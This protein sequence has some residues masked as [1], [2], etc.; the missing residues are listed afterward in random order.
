MKRLKHYLVCCLEFVFFLFIFIG[1]CHANPWLTAEERLEKVRSYYKENHNFDANTRST[2]IVEDFYE[3]DLRY[4]RA[5]YGKALNASVLLEALEKMDEEVRTFIG[6]KGRTLTFNEYNL[7]TREWLWAF[8][9]NIVLKEEDYNTIRS[10]ANN[11]D[12]LKQKVVRDVIELM[13]YRESINKEEETSVCIRLPF[14]HVTGMVDVPTMNR[15]CGFFFD[16]EQTT[17]VAFMGVATSPRV[18]YDSLVD[19]LASDGYDHDGLHATQQGFYDGDRPKILSRKNALINREIL[20]VADRHK[21][22][23]LDL[24]FFTASHEGATFRR[25]NKSIYCKCDLIKYSA[26]KKLKRDDS[27]DERELCR[28]KSLIGMAQSLGLPIADYPELSFRE[29]VLQQWTEYNQ[30][31]AQGCE[32]LMNLSLQ[33]FPEDKG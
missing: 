8:S 1:I 12:S 16:E 4:I 29:R 10:C 3:P 26:T 22:S 5:E 7:I 31:L 30:H 33:L 21:R 2:R 11:V 32:L 27:V 18:N 17:A 19:Q 9:D 20:A 24:A 6:A 15:G 23:L 25:E 28:Y 13:Q 14:V